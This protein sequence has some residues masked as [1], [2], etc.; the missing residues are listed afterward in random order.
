MAH[1]IRRSIAAIAIAAFGSL[2]S[3]A[4]AAG[5][6]SRIPNKQRYRVSA[7][8][9]ATIVIAATPD[10]IPYAFPITNARIISD[11]G[12]AQQQGNGVAWVDRV[13]FSAELERTP[14]QLEGAARLPEQRRRA[15]PHPGRAE[16]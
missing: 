3:T 6:P 2:A 13:R 11:Y 7:T 10:N 15:A 1:G 16:Q 5:G 14:H 12:R 8:A 4:P 9:T